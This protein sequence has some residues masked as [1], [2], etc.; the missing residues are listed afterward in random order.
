MK[1]ILVLGTG[2]AQADLIRA[3]KE[4]GWE[5][6]AC[7]YR[8]GDPGEK[9]ADHFEL[10]NIV[11]ADAVADYAARNRV[12]AVY[13]AG[14]D[15]AMPTA[16]S[17]SERLGLPQFCPTE[18]AVICNTKTL[19]RKT[20]GRD[21]AGNIPYQTLRSKDE[22]VE[23]S[24]PLMVK[25]EDSQGQ[26]GVFCAHDHGELLDRF[27]ESMHF[28]R[29]KKLILEERIEGDEISINTFSCD[30]KLLFFLPSERISWEGSSGGIIHR[31][32]LPGKWSSDHA[33]MD[34]VRDL[35]DRTLR[36]LSILNG[37]AYFQIM[38]DQSGTPYLIEVTPRLDGCHMWR[39][40]RY[41][42]GID[43][44]DLTVNALSGE[45]RDSLP[46]YSAEPFETE[47]LCQA[48]D[49]PFRRDQF[50]LGEYVY[51]EWYYKDGDI[52]NRMNGYK[53]K[54]GYVIR[55]LAKK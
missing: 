31:H 30:G 16:F 22:R 24:Y 43:L 40:I 49:I 17:V 14:S 41:S 15:I 6:H 1:K 39:L 36:R 45:K 52:V 18:S 33:A 38:M 20:L 21:F 10:I 26:R 4:K 54:G 19:L 27:D 42:T 11:D 25:P 32:I 50:E 8:S 13:S 47:F 28:S 2:A 55:R 29:S 12:D 9:L 48:P 46:P 35:V 51:L 44:L 3:C 23:L 53:E 34:R 5:V 7:S 37:P